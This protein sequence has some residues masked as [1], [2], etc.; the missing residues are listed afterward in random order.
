MSMHYE[1]TL[2]LRLRRDVHEAFLAELRYHLGL[3]DVAPEAPE[4]DSSC[5]ALVAFG[6][7]AELPAPSPPP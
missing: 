4:L 6:D 2:S 1:W 7:G 5:Q 3:S